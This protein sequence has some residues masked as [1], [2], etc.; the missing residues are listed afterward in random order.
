[1]TIYIED[2]RVT[3]ANERCKIAVKELMEIA[4]RYYSD[5]NM[6]EY[7]RLMG[8]VEGVQLAQ[9]YFNQFLKDSQ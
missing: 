2:T 6:E 8:K 7:K 1:M 5:G 9:D 4:R 3:E